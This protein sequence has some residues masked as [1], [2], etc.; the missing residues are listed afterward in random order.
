MEFLEHVEK[1]LIAAGF[2]KTVAHRKHYETYSSLITTQLNWDVNTCLHFYSPPFGGKDKDPKAY[3]YHQCE[4]KSPILPYGPDG[5]KTFTEAL[6]TLKSTYRIMDN[7]LAFHDI[8]GHRHGTQMPGLKVEVRYRNE[9]FPDETSKNLLAILWTFEKLIDTIHPSYMIDKDA[10]ITLRDNSALAYAMKGRDWYGHGAKPPF[11]AAE[12]LDRIFACSTA[13]EAVELVIHSDPRWMQVYWA[14]GFPYHDDSEDEKA[15]E[16]NDQ[17][18]NQ[19]D[20]DDDESDDEDTEPALSYPTFLFNGHESTFE[21]ARFQNWIKVCLGL[22]NFAHRADPES[23]KKWL[24]SHTKDEKANGKAKY[25]VLKNWLDEYTKDL[26]EKGDNVG[27]LAT[28]LEKKLTHSE[29]AEYTVIE[30]L[31]DVG[32]EEQ[33]EYYKGKTFVHDYDLIRNWED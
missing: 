10:A 14:H 32:L 12:A 27:G 7:D 6:G 2:P 13:G 8:V 18:S 4:I 29:A 15:Q 24:L 28:D 9:T 1:T 30:L 3:R 20:S 33:A 16:S 23:L 26:K 5:L 31:K 25:D 22:V 19:E 17:A 11:S 21:T